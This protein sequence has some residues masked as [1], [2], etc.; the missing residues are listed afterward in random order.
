M[1]RAGALL[2]TGAQVKP[3]MALAHAM[4]RRGGGG[5]GRVSEL[6]R[7]MRCASLALAVCLGPCQQ[8]TDRDQVGRRSEHLQPG[9]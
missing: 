9:D 3:S 8:L 2:V 6:S 7:S 1:L 4:P 5:M